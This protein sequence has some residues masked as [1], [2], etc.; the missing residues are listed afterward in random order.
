MAPLKSA[1]L[2]DI[3][4]PPI[5]S[6][7]PEN[8][9]PGD[10]MPWESACSILK[11]AP[12]QTTLG[13]FRVTLRLDRTVSGIRKG[14]DSFSGR[15]VPH[16]NFDVYDRK[17]Y[18]D[19]YAA[20]VW[21]EPFVPIANPHRALAFPAN[22]VSLAQLVFAAMGVTSNARGKRRANRAVGVSLN[23]QS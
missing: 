14:L 2:D 18:W 1:R 17:C 4:S 22:E 12:S 16:D 10:P 15:L 19:S 20:L 21:R 6:G 23:E 7:F 11:C 5:R 9:L 3:I 8:F 13:A